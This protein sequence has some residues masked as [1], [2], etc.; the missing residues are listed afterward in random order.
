MQLRESREIT[1]EEFE[2]LK[3]ESNVLTD[4]DDYVRS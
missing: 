2:A 3:K 4:P 1:L